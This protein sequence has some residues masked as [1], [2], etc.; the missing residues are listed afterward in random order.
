MKPMGISKKS[1]QAGERVFA[2]SVP[3]DAI[4]M[5]D[6]EKLLPSG[7]KVA[8]SLKDNRW[9]ISWGP[10]SRSRCWTLCGE[11][12]AFLLCAKCLWAEYT[13]AGQGVCPW[14]DILK[15]VDQD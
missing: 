9:R 13:E 15:A 6:A 4:S 10:F 12:Q 7:S 3:A 5:A 2:A 14:P 8:K 1:I 11:F